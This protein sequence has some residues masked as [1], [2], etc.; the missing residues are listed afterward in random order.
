MPDPSGLLRVGLGVGLTLVFLLAGSVTP[1]S[2]DDLSA[3]ELY[4][5]LGSASRIHQFGGGR[6]LYVLYDPQCP[7]CGTFFHRLMDVE[8]A[9]RE[10]GVSVSWVP[11]AILGSS[12]NPQAQTQLK[13]GI[14]ELKAHFRGDRSPLTNDDRLRRAIKANTDLM[15]ANARASGTPSLVFRTDERVHIISG[16]PGRKTLRRIMKNIR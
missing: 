2:A 15:K 3:G 13:R 9:V 12:S 14:G 4:N 6:T 10:A 8:D 1:L 16:A 5:R 7:V 11:V